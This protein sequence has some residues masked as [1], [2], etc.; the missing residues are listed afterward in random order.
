MPLSRPLKGVL[1]P[2]R[3]IVPHHIETSQ[4]IYIS[5]QLTGFYMMGTLVVKIFSTF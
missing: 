2:V 5:N 3:D 1:N 4:L